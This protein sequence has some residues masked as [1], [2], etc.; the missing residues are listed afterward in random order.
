MP[1]V[2]SQTQI[3]FLHKTQKIME[4]FFRSEV[5]KEAKKERKKG[6]LTLASQEFFM[7]R[8]VRKN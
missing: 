8:N 5:N 4:F 2:H 6:V 3:I 1:R 7:P